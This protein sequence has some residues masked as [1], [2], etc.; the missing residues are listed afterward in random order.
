MLADRG[1]DVWMGNSR[2]TIYSQQHVQ[3]DAE[4]DAEYWDHSYE[5]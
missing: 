5:L 1:Y 3:Y 4:S 2:G